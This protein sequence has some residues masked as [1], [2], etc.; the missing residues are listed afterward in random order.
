MKS[1]MQRIGRRKAEYEYEQE[2]EYDIAS[3]IWMV[4][5]RSAHFRQA[6]RADLFIERYSHDGFF[7]AP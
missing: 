1:D 3:N 2:Y 5:Q 4:H 7:A 6:R